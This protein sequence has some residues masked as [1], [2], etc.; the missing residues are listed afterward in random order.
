MALSKIK[1][2]VA[3]GKGGVGKSLISSS[4]SLL[5]SQDYLVT[6]LDADVDAP[7]LHLWL[8]QDEEWEELKDISTG[9]R[10]VIDYGKCNGCQKCVDACAFGALSFKDHR[11]SINKYLC[12]GCGACQMVCPRQAITMKPVKNAQ[13]RVKKVH[14]D[15]LNRFNREI[16]LIS[17][18]LYP[19]Y[20]GS[21]QVVDILK[22]ECEKSKYEV[23]IVDSPAG[24]GCPVIAAL[25]DVDFVVLVTEP[26][27]AGASDLGRV[28]EVVSHFNLPFG[29]VINKWDINTTEARRIQKE[30]KR[31]FLGKIA[32]DKRIFKSISYLTP[33]MM[34]NLPAKKE[35]KDIFNKMTKKD[36]KRN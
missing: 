20:T 4:L 12:E 23:M 1:I 2:A 17:G 8:G 18:Q 3:S 24:T 28:L 21:G 32:Y 34:T 16:V 6:A 33:V 27:P 14:F 5:F 31:E 11:L 35:I 10:P 15:N 19:G 25:K 36:I 7:N 30:F 22:E 26:T 9:K 13:L 29:V